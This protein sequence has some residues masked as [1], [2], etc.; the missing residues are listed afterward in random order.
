MS[1]LYFFTF[2]F[3]LLTSST[4]L[5]LIL[6]NLSY[7]VYTFS[8]IISNLLYVLGSFRIYHI[9]HYNGQSLHR[10][11][12][13][14][15]NFIAD[16]FVHF[17]HYFFH[18]TTAINR[19]AHFKFQRISPLRRLFDFNIFAARNAGT[20]MRLFLINDSMTWSEKVKRP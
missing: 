7:Y 4:A 8:K 15:F 6:L 13:N 1:F 3:L 14:V 5:Q 18:R 11:A 20:L 19:Y 12:C 10:H 9:I 17:T 16:S 2:Y